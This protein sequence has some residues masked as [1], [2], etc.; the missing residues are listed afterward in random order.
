[1]LGGNDA[2]RSGRTAAEEEA[3]AAAALAAQS[4]RGAGGRGAEGGAGGEA[5]AAALRRPG[6]A[7]PPPAFACRAAWGVAGV[8]RRRAE[9]FGLLPAAQLW[10]RGSPVPPGTSAPRRVN[11]SPGS[12]ASTSPTFWRSRRWARSPCRSRGHGNTCI[13]HAQLHCF[14]LPRSTINFVTGFKKLLSRTVPS[15]YLREN[16]LLGRVEPM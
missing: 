7:S 11:G 4:C 8:L 15:D 5:R 3:V 6:G 13:A 12:A 16:S 1:M 2:S 9:R 10:L 14:H